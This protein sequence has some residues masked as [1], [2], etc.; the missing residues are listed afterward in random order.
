MECDWEVE[1]GAGCPVIDAA[2]DG[3][4]DL[5]QTPGRISQ[6]HEATHLPA[7]RD[8]LTRLNSSSSPVFTAKCDVWVPDSF[9]AD[10]LDARPESAISGLA[11]YIDLIPL[12]ARLASDLNAIVDWCKRLCTQLKP[13]PLPAC[14]LDAIARRSFI[15]TDEKAFG[16]TLYVSACGPSAQQA[17]QA[18]SV[19]LAT[20][21]DSVISLGDASQHPS[22]YNQS[23][24]GE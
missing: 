1:I 8:T 24:V 16:V 10:E 22:K 5:R 15:T 12:D 21:T 11:T 2:W 18:L 20:V 17:S 19:A 13:R 7:L 14:R 3:Y 23:I 9:D 6:I 4:I